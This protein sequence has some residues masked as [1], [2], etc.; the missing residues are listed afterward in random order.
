M[1]MNSPFEQPVVLPPDPDDSAAQV[2]AA[3]ATFQA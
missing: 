1:A 2:A 3:L